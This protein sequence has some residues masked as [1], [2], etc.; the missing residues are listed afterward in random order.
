MTAYVHKLVEHTIAL[1]RLKKQNMP[2]QSAVENTSETANAT[3]NVHLC[4]FV[5]M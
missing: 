3:K 4:V 5:C 1:K 2:A